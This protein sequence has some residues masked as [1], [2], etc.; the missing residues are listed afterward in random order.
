[1]EKENQGDDRANRSLEVFFGFLGSGHGF[2][3]IEIFA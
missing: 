1:M 2:V 3:H